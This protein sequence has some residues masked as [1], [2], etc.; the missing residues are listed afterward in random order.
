MKPITPTKRLNV[1]LWVF[2]ALLA[3][4]FLAHGWMMLA[5]P[6]EIVD[7]M[8]AAMSRGLQ[9]FIGV[10]EVLAAVGLTLPGIARIATGLVPAAAGGLVIIMVLATGFHIVRAEISSAVITAVLLALAGF[11]TYARW[12]V[13][14]IPSRGRVQ[15]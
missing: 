3:L 5:P 10:S 1:V 14:P 8:N 6:A 9:V 12:K 2:Q 13:L 7:Q 11:V 4:V 15:A